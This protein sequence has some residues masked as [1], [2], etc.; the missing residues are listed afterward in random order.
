[1]NVAPRKSAKIQSMMV[2]IDG[3]DDREAVDAVI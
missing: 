1:L 3:G 2:V